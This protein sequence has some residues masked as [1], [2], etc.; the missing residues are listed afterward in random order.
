MNTVNSYNNKYPSE[1]SSI[2]TIT[3]QIEEG[4]YDKLI[5][6]LQGFAK[7]NDLEF[8]PSF[9]SDKKFFVEIDGKGLQIAVSPKPITTTEIYI[10]FF[11]KD[12][13]NPPSQK[14]VDDLFND[15]KIFISE[16]QNVTFTEEK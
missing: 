2:R 4:Q 16:I 3:I 11:E 7:K 5:N 15:L 1:K 10:S 6:Q 14:V 12:P 9:Y 13:T 8:H